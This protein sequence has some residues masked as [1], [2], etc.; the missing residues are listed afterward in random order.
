MQNNRSTPYTVRVLA[1]RTEQD[2]RIV[3]QKYPLNAPVTHRYVVKEVRL[4]K[5]TGEAACLKYCR[6]HYGLEWTQA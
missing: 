6:E 4:T 2:G 3:V 1:E 5:F